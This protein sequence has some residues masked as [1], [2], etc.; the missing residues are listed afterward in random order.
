MIE[1]IYK[2]LT[3]QA[4][5]KNLSNYQDLAKLLNLNLK[6][7]SDRN[8]I[9]DFL[10]AIAVSEHDAKR[11]MLT[12]LVLQQK[13]NND[14][15]ETFYDHARH[16]GLYWGSRDYMDR[17]N[18]W[19]RQVSLVHIHWSPPPQPPSPPPTEPTPPET[20]SKG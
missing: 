13:N 8:L 19:I 7:K 20:N 14:P 4:K 12:A 1:T 6:K 15:G 2:E 3:R 17:L 9:V 16:L 10:Q 11:P 18:F 5:Q